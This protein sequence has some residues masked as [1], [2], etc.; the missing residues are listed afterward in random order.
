MDYVI[1]IHR[2]TYLT[3]VEAKHVRN[4]ACFVALGAAA[5]EREASGGGA[6]RG[7][8]FEAATN[9]MAAVLKGSA[10]PIGMSVPAARPQQRTELAP[11]AGDI[12]KVP[13]RWQPGAMAVGGVGALTGGGLL[14]GDPDGDWRHDCCYGNNFP[15]ARIDDD[16]SSS[17]RQ[18]PI[19]YGA[20]MDG[21]EPLDVEHPAVLAAV[22]FALP[23]VSAQEARVVSARRLRLRVTNDGGKTQVVERLAYQGTDGRHASFA[24]PVTLGTLFFLHV[25]Q[26]VGGGVGGQREHR[27]VVNLATTGQYS[28]SQHTW[29]D[30][31][32]GA[33]GSTQSAEL[34]VDAAGAVVGG[35][36]GS[37]AAA[38]AESLRTLCYN[39]WNT[40][41]P[42]W[43]LH[44]DEKRRDWYFRRMTH[45]A[46]VVRAAR[47]PIIALQEVRFDSSLGRNASQI[48]HIARELGPDYQFVYHPAMLYYNR[49]QADILHREEEGP[50][51]LSRWP[52]RYTD[53][54]LLSH[55]PADKDDVHQ[56]VCLHAVVDVPGWGAVDVFTAH[57]SLSEPAREKTMLEIWE[58]VQRRSIG[59]IQLLMGDFNAEPDSRGIRFLQ[60]LG[61]LNGIRTDFEDCWLALHPEPKPRSNDTNE[62]D[63]MLTFPS[64]NPVKRIDFVLLRRPGDAARRAV[65]VREARLMGQAPLA[66]TEEFEG[67]GML[68]V[69]PPSPIWA[70]DHRAVFVELGLDS[71]GSKSK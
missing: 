17:P 70:S 66:G 15:E 48:E 28:L 27:L 21:A 7:L 4:Y 61:A 5:A 11:V 30:A 38:P 23:G 44:N 12:R 59:E 25:A 60:G 10:R 62:V 47:A 8:A 19:A 63:N 65:S 24:F 22:S 45:F 34:E 69:N 50:A 51:I 49:D 2:I 52:V 29:I 55:D 13:G 46:D 9:E 53:F 67:P 71:L 31:G 1:H 33:S 58:F 26:A 6:L 39:I 18:C 3:K 32:A 20:I 43:L 56:R 35:G 40:N 57:L 36:G 14:E 64:C 37:A 16:R 68:D 42:M 54:A 41:P